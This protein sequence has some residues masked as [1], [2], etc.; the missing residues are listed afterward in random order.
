MRNFEGGYV[1]F[2]GRRVAGRAIGRVGYFDGREDSKR[3]KRR[4][5]GLSKAGEN[6]KR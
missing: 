5:T 6:T 4:D 1:S 3:T 2:G